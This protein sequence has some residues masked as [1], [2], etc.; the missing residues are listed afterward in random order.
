M[1][2]MPVR[3]AVLDAGPDRHSVLVLA[4]ALRAGGLRVEQVTA[5]TVMIR[6]EDLPRAEAIARALEEQEQELE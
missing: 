4:A 5:T 3:F 1:P 6:A 2:S